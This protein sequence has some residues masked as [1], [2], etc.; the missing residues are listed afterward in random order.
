MEIELRKRVIEIFKILKEK[1][2]GYSASDLAEEL[3]IDYIVLMSAINDLKDYHLADFKEEEIYEISL[4]EEGSSYLN[5]GLPERQLL[6]IILDEDLREINI[7]DLLIYFLPC[8]LNL[9]IVY[10][11]LL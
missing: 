3:G 11:T 4:N 10:S 6:Q 9:R 8:S 1:E 5:K 7:N 2:K